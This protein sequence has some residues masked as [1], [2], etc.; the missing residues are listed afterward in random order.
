MRPTVLVDSLPSDEPRDFLIAPHLKKKTLKANHHSRY[1]N[2]PVPNKVARFQY[3]SLSIMDET[4]Q[5]II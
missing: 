4:D 5:V 3:V 1:M 2:D